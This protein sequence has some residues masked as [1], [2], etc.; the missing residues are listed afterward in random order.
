MRKI[1]FNDALGLTRATIP[2]TGRGCGKKKAMLEEI[3]RFEKMTAESVLRKYTNGYEAHLIDKHPH[4][5]TYRDPRR[6]LG[7]GAFPE[8]KI[9]L[10]Q[11]YGCVV[12]FLETME[13]LD[14]IEKQMHL[15]RVEITNDKKRNE[16]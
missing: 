6:P 9:M 10:L 5:L 14:R 16:V 12:M 11:R 4:G 7:Y 13:D 15:E 3:E 8:E 1:M 2:D